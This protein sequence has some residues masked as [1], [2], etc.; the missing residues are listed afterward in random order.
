[1]AASNQVGSHEARTYV[2]DADWQAT[3]TGEL[4]QTLE[5]VRLVALR[6]R[7][8]RCRTESACA[9]YRR[10]ASYAPT[11]VVVGKPLV[12]RQHHS[13]KTNGIGLH[14]PHLL[15]RIER[16][17]LPPYSR[18]VE[19]Q[20][21]AAQ[22]ANKL[23]QAIGGIVAVHINLLPRHYAVRGLHNL[24]QPLHTSAS[25]AYAVATHG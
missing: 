22:L 21:H 11:V 20:I 6:S 13:C 1:M 24:L 19:V 8:S 12:S 5:V 14:R 9:G 23:M 2:G 15:L 16:A 18:A 4:R 25:Y 17:V 3:H 7:I 10:Y